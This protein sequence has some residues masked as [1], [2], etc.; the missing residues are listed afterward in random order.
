MEAKACELG[1]GKTLY[2]LFPSNNFLNDTDIR[3]VAAL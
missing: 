3:K 2:Y 1:I